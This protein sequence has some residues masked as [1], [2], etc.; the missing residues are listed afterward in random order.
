[1]PLYTMR[2]DLWVEDNEL[3]INIEGREGIFEL[4]AE[5][6]RCGDT[7]GDETPTACGFFET[8]TL[9]ELVAAGYIRWKEEN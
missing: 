1:M 7:L 2:G 6:P 4:D 9:A 8:M 5:C 3:H